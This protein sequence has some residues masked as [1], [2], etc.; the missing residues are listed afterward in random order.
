MGQDALVLD[1]LFHVPNPQPLSPR[2][3]P[4]TGV[5]ESRCH[6]RCWP[7]VGTLGQRGNA[8]WVWLWLI[9][10]KLH[11]GRDILIAQARL[12]KHAFDCSRSF[13]YR[14]PHFL[15]NGINISHSHALALTKRTS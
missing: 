1:C 3:D 9:D 6:H 11:E 15:E 5:V 4:S 10:L 12:L 2:L 13:P 7:P 14:T 8:V